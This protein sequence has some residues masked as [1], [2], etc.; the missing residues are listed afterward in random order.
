M[1]GCGPDRL[2]DGTTGGPNAA[3][4]CSRLRDDLWAIARCG[5]VARTPVPFPGVAACWRRR[6]ACLAPTLVPTLAL[7]H[8]PSRGSWLVSHS[9]DGWQLFYRNLRPN[10]RYTTASRELPVS[11]EDRSEGVEVTLCFLLTVPA[12]DGDCPRV[13]LFDNRKPTSWRRSV[14]SCPFPAPTV[15]RQWSAR[16]LL[17]PLGS[18]AGS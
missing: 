8:C 10:R 6:S 7:S 11:A 1:D 16:P 3:R 9:E 15:P 13:P 4:W 5:M 17:L 14:S 2:G 12:T 18:D